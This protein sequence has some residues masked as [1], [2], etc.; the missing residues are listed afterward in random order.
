MP[1]LL[2]IFLVIFLCTTKIKKNQ[3]LLSISLFSV[4]FSATL[5][6]T[7]LEKSLLLMQR[8]DKTEVNKHD[9]KKALAVL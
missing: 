4:M 9:F 3:E 6:V 5:V 2:F 8:F 1:L 7:S